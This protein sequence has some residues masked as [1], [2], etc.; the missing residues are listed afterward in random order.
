MSPFKK[1]VNAGLL[2]EIPTKGQGQRG[3]IV[4]KAYKPK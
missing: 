1:L 3:R 4:A 2:V